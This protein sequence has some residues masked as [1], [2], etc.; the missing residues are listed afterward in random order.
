MK[1]MLS[2]LAMLAMLALL[3]GLSSCSPL[4]AKPVSSD[5]LLE[6]LSTVIA[7]NAPSEQGADPKKSDR[8][9]GEFDGAPSGSDH[10]GAA[11]YRRICVACHDPG[12]NFSASRGAP[13]LGNLEAWESRR[14]KG[15][16][17]LAESVLNPQDGQMIMPRADLTDDEVRSVIAF[18]LQQAEP[19]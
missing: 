19:R 13:R 3:G 14:R 17:V 10:P 16:N 1:W 5:Q 9:K 2:L 8:G 12:S 11:L 7:A 4:P 18:M 6:K 15:V